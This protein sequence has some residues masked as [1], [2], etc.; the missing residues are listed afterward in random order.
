MSKHKHGG[1]T[2]REMRRESAR[3]GITTSKRAWK[4]SRRDHGNVRQPKRS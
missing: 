2:I 3:A 1:Y 4:H